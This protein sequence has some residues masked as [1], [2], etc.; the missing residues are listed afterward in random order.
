MRDL[1]L[2]ICIP[3]YNGGERIVKSVKRILQSQDRRFEIVICDNR[4]TDGSIKKLQ[5]ISDDRLHININEENVG[6]LENGLCVLA[7][8][9]GKY[10]MQLLDRDIL[11]MEYLSAYIDMLAVQEAG[12]ILNLYVHAG[13]G[14]N[15]SLVKTEEAAYWMMES[16]HPSF[17]VFLKEAFQKLPI[18]DWLKSEG[19]YSAGC[20]L[21][22]LRN[23]AAVLQREY[24]IIIEAEQEYIYMNSS[25]SH[26]YM[27]AKDVDVEKTGGNF[28]EDSVLIRFQ[29]YISF[30]KEHWRQMD[31]GILLGIYM[32]DL[33]AVSPG[34]FNIIRS[35][36]HCHRYSIKD[37]R[38]AS[39]EYKKLPFR[40]YR[41]AKHAL[42]EQRMLSLSLQWKMWRE[43]WR[44]R[45]KFC[46]E[47]CN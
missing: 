44:C 41:R 29:K 40:F 37:K 4:S 12:V 3:V 33:N 42:R 30:V 23:Y 7:K 2:S 45:R 21:L 9:N 32:A 25:R 8:G 36:L 13:L 19:Y 27:N 47:I 43:T 20:G 14:S 24:P 18:T 34:Y 39:W 6:P 26:A 10:L 28:D 11:Q 5:S 1:I 16:P 46:R 38:Y 17:Y 22:I 35:C 15:R 31:R